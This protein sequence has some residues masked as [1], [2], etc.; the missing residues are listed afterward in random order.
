MVLPPGESINSYWK[1]Q[2]EEGDDGSWKTF[3]S[4]FTYVQATDTGAETH[5][6]NPSIPPNEVVLH[7]VADVRGVARDP[8][9]A[10]ITPALPARPRPRFVTTL[11]EEILDRFP[12]PR[13]LAY[14]I[15][16]LKAGSSRYRVARA[17][18]DSREHRRLVRQH[19]DPHIP[20]R[21]AFLDAVRA[22]RSAA[23]SIAI[24]RVLG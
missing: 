2:N 4:K 10:F 20:L 3:W 18:F 6:T 11:Y 15:G 7:L 21:R 16:R 17:I 8:G 5:A 19:L 24:P 14:W 1:Y 13:G 12:E 9:G 23:H 22:E